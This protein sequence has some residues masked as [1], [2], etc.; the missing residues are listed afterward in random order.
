MCLQFDWVGEYCAK[1]AIRNA[2][3]NRV[4]GYKNNRSTKYYKNYRNSSCTENYRNGTEYKSLLVS[5]QVYKIYTEIAENTEV[6]KL[7]VCKIY[8]A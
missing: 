1:V 8:R 4:K 6:V 5:V 3:N 7:E 2:V